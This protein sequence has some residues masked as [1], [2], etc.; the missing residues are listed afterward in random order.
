LEVGVFVGGATFND[1]SSKVGVEEGFC[2]VGLDVG[3]DEGFDVVG[4]DV[5]VEVGGSHADGLEVGTFV[6]GVKD[7]G[8]DEGAEVVEHGGSTRQEKGLILPW[9]KSN[10]YMWERGTSTTFK[11]L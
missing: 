7:E 2:V 1:V 6:D 10:E 8:F 11:V 4:M 9:Y 3:V 5:G